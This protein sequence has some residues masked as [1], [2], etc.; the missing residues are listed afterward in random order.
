MRS[1]AFAC[2]RAVYDLNE[3]KGAP[4]RIPHPLLN[5]MAIH[6]M[7]AP[8]LAQ[9]AGIAQRMVAGLLKELNLA[10]FDPL[11]GDVVLDKLAGVSPR[12]LRKT[13][14]DSLGYAVADGQGADRV[15]IRPAGVMA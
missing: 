14:L 1:I 13:L 2:T 7:P 10:A 11:L 9:A 15:L 4:D 5:R 3:V 12:D 8:A 6:D